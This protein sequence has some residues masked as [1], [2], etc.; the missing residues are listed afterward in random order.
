MLAGDVDI[1]LLW[2]VVGA[3]AIGCTIVILL[4][5]VLCLACRV[6]RA[7]NRRPEL[8]SKYL[9]NSRGGFMSDGIDGSRHSA[10]DSILGTGYDSHGLVRQETSSGQLQKMASAESKLGGAGS[11]DHSGLLIDPALVSVTHKLAAGAY[12]AVYLGVFAGVNVVVKE[13]YSQMLEGD[14]EELLHEARMLHSLRHPRIVT[15]YGVTWRGSGPAPAGWKGGGGTAPHVTAASVDMDTRDDEEEYSSA[16]F[17]G[18][19]GGTSSMNDES[20]LAES[21]NG[22]QL[23]SRSAPSTW[24]SGFLAPRGGSGGSMGDLHVGG[25]DVFSLNSQPSSGGVTPVNISRPR[26]MSPDS[27][28]WAGLM[29]AAEDEHAKLLLVT[30]YCGQGSLGEAIR[31]GKYDTHANFLRHAVQLAGT[32]DWL[33]R[34]SPAIIHRDIK[35]GNMLLDDRG[36]LKLCDLGLARAQPLESNDTNGNGAL[37]TMTGGLGS[38]PFVPPE[39]MKGGAHSD[40]FDDATARSA[41]SLSSS[42][43]SPSSLMTDADA[44]WDIPPSSSAG[45]GDLKS[46]LAGTPIMVSARRACLLLSRSLSLSLL[47]LSLSLSLSA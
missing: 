38:A 42:L 3:S 34:K 13:L 43:L 46:Y 26:A 18:G 29:Q 23:L 30:E 28:A 41:R 6:C 12:G 4:G 5:V 40:E 33:H 16:S 37:A 21:V 25:S 24:N 10:Y 15:F 1:P 7:S 9:L 19:R 17:D 32:L 47:S 22:E 36:D 39:I 44:P 35:P 27:Q 45:S 2:F 11:G 8:G 31:K 14:N 20:W